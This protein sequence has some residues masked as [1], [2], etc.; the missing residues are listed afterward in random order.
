MLLEFMA[1]AA[2]TARYEFD[3]VCGMHEPL[4]IDWQPLIQELIYDYARSV[5]PS[6]VAARFHN[7]LV[8]MIVKIASM[9][10]EKSVALSG[11]CFQNKF[12]TER[13][14]SRLRV[15]GFKVYW[16]QRV[17]TNDG[18]ISLGQVIAANESGNDDPN[19]KRRLESVCV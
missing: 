12:L 1:D 14:I 13:A 2:E 5:R 4:I 10:G 6:C 18:G 15:E 8:E 19:S 3:V 11:G 17:P 9:S 16:H 7:T